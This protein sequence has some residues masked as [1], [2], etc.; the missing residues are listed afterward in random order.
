MIKINLLPVKASRRVEA[1]KE[2]ALLAAIAAAVL[3]MICAA[4]FVFMQSAISDVKAENDQLSKEIQ[5]LRNIVARVDEIDEIKKDL[6]Q[7]LSVIEQL[8]KKKSGPVHM[9]DELSEA[10]PEK[11]SLEKLAEDGGKVDL[12]GL[13]VSNEVISQFLSN[14]ERSEWFSDVFLVGIDQVEQDGYKLKEFQVTAKVAPPK[15]PEEIA[16]EEAAAAKAAKQ[17]AEE[18][19]KKGKKG[20]KAQGGEE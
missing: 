5:N 18:S 1:V 20:K 7:K 13:A 11:V 19:G 8:K 3:A 12:A 15:T 14:L 4:I 16:A 6:T 10:T 17:A 9:L 2:E